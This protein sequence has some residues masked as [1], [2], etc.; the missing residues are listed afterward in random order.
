MKELSF[1]SGIRLEGVCV[2]I[3]KFN[4]ADKPWKL[5]HSHFML[6]FTSEERFTKDTVSKVRSLG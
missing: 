3:L 5:S 2:V 1:C 6:A 4:G